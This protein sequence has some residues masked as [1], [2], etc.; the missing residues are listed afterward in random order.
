M[1]FLGGS[2]PAEA[3]RP[4]L[5]EAQVERKLST[6]LVAD[7][8]GS[9][10][11]M[12][13]DEEGTLRAL[14]ASR[15]D[16]RSLVGRHHGRVF[17]GAGDSV[18]AEFASAVEAVRCAV[19]IQERLA[20]G[21]D[22]VAR[23]DFRI[24]LHLGDVI[25]DGQDLM[26]DGVNVAVRIESLAEARGIC[27]SA[28]VLDQVEG[29]LPLLFEPL[30]EQMLKNLPRPV[31][32]YRVLRGDSR[33][34]GAVAAAGVP[35]IAVLP[36]VPIGAESETS[37][38]DGIAEDVTANL[39]RF[40]ELQ[41]IAWNSTRTYRGR[42]VGSDQVGRE[43]GVRYVVE[44]NVRLAAG[45]ARIHARLLAAADGG[46]V[47]AER[48][49]R[50]VTDIFAVQDDVA[51][52][53]VATLVDRVEAVELAR[54]RRGGT[55]D[56]RAYGLF[57]AA[58]E[59]AHRFTEEDNARARALLGQ[60]LELDPAFARAHAVLA[61]CRI[62]DWRYRWGTSPEAMMELAEIAARQAILLDETN[63]HGHIA[64]GNV[65]LYAGEVDPAMAEYDRAIALNPHDPDV[66]VEYGSAL[67]YV[68]RPGEGLVLLEKAVALN[69]VA[70][71]WY[72]WFLGDAHF[73]RGAYAEALRV[74][75]RMRDPR[76]GL[77]LLAASATLVGDVEAA[78]A[79]GREVLRTQPGFTISRWASTLPG[80]DAEVMNRFV[81][82]LKG[83]GLPP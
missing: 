30:G 17:G 46:Q 22:G 39:A 25:I 41:V 77:R 7:A 42:S 33:A 4:R 38:I 64:L 59:H 1:P 34:R 5:P 58:Q 51:Q 55:Y 19:A 81:E 12:S 10:R 73:C 23:L 44:G 3:V 67:A 31:R 45:R 80:S 56:L 16:I 75:G 82:G 28:T 48:Y 8:V 66:L 76:Q 27:V 68:G 24:G 70:P 63:A 78:R 36:F 69:P 40:R 18:L 26:G 29:K 61:M 62:H 65:H 20:E 53:I 37:F 60:A 72:L 57:V 15:D 54:M 79:Y 71:D 21:R 11:L 52:K 9:S 13:A 43:L 2:P 14:T 74:L 50:E 49:D 35:T 32:V 47:W 83:A 6:I